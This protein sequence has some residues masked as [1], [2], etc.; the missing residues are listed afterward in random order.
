MTADQTF[1]DD[2]Y[3]S[4]KH[5]IEYVATLDSNGAA[6]WFDALR[7]GQRLAQAIKDKGF[8]DQCRAWLAKASPHTHDLIGSSAEISLAGVSMEMEAEP[9][10]V[11]HP[12]KIAKLAQAEAPASR[13]YLQSLQGFNLNLPEGRLTLAPSLPTG[14]TAISGPI[15]TPTIVGRMEYTLGQ[16]RA[17]LLFRVDRYFSR[18]MTST[19]NSPGPG[20]TIKEIGLPEIAGLTQVVANVGRSPLPGKLSRDSNGQLLFTADSPVTLTAGERVEFTF[21]PAE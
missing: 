17:H 20:L 10:R 2:F 21:R 15:Y 3:P 8:E 4:A 19:K 7:I 9:E 13:L 1:L 16:K 5:A 18:G 14:W 12:D 6:M 11:A